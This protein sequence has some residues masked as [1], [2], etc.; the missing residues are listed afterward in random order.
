MRTC[1]IQ[2][3]KNDKFAKRY[4]SHE[5][6]AGGAFFIMGYWRREATG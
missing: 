3:P 4:A 5:N 6:G 1:L 2:V